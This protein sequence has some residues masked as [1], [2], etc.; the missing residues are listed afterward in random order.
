MTS[1]SEIGAQAELA[2]ATALARSGR[3]VFVPFFNGH[4]RIDLVFED[5]TGRLNRVQ[6]KTSRL[7][8]GCIGF[9]TCSNT[10]NVPKEYA[11]EIDVFGVYSPELDAVFIVPIDDVPTRFC[12]LRVAPPANNQ[13]RGIRWAAP[14]R[15]APP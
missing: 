5:E 4:G 15:L 6:C 7:N 1:P 9:R 10:G 14:Y 8:D 2:V 12:F 11:G 3:P 13:Q